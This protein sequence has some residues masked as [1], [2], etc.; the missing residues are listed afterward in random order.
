V[1]TFGAAEVLAAMLGSSVGAGADRAGGSFVSAC[2]VWVAEAVAISAVG[3]G[4]GGVDRGHPTC[5]GEK[6][7]GGT[8]LGCFFLGDRNDH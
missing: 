4:V 6:A 7:D 8:N 5:A 3:G 2:L 1:A